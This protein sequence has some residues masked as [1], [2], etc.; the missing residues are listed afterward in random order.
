MKDSTFTKSASDGHPLFVYGFLPDEGT[1]VRAVIHVAH[2]MAEH[3]A[4]YRRLAESLTPQGYAVYAHDHRGHGSTA[5]TE[6]DLG[7]FAPAN[8]WSRVVDDLHE[9]IQ[10]A[11]ALHPGVPA[12]ALGHS[13]GSYMVQTLLYR[14]PDAIAAAVLAGSSGP[15][16]ALASAGRLVARAERLRLGERGKSPVIR[17]LTFDAFNKAFHPARTAY[18][19]LSRDSAEVDA[20]AQD[21]R[22][23]F[24][25]ST[26]LWVDV[27][28]ALE[29]NARLENLL[30]IRKDIPVYLVA[31][32]EDPVGERTQSVERLRDAYRRAGLYRLSHRYYEGA[33]HEVFNETNRAEVTK[34]LLTWLDKNVGAGGPSAP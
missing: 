7:F 33:R 13:M 27:L 2:G 15:P 8:G 6:D 23:G 29:E 30:R 1:P 9:L 21:P 10:H 4:R 14:Y 11:R 34:D 18:D 5:R 3:A 31:G 17:A 28:D 19:W 22:C 32:A 16:S 26:A 24:S 12:V 25:C 20:Y